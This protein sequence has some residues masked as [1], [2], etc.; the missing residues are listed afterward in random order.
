MVILDDDH[1][2]HYGILRKSGRYP[3]G[4][5]GNT[6]LERSQDF[7]SIT[8]TL[9]EQGMNEG[10]IAKAVGL[11]RSQLR[12]TKTI[13][14]N[15]QRQARIIEAQRLSDKGYG[16]TAAAAKMGI[17][18]STYRSL[19][20]PGA[21]DRSDILTATTDTL[22]KEVAE[23]KYVDVGTGVETNLGISKEKLR[24]AASILEEEGYPIHQVNFPQAATGKETRMKVLCAKG[25]TQKE[26]WLNRSEIRPPHSFSDDGGRTYGGLKIHD[27]IA[28]DPKRVSIKYGDEGGG[29]ADGVIFVRPGVKDLSLGKANYAQVRVKVGNDHYLKGMA[30]YKDDLPA[31]TDLL[32]NTAKKS[33]GNKFDAMKPI[34]DDPD[35]PFGSVVRQIL[36]DKG[37]DTEHVTSAMNLVY[38]EGNWGSW[39]KSLSSQFLSKQDPKVARDQLDLTFKRRKQEL[40]DLLVLTNPTVKKKLLE[41]YAGKAD[42]SAVHLE[43]AQMNTRQQW[44]AILPIE[45]MPHSHVYAPN[46]K[47]GEPVVL[48]RYPHAGRFEI[49]ELTVDNNNREARKLIGNAPD[50]I[51]IHTSVAHRLSGADFDGDTVIVIPNQGR[52]IK[53]SPALAGLKNFDPQSAYPGY[54]GMELLSPRRKQQEMGK[55]SNL[56]TDMTIK[57]AD[58]EEI[59][60][61]VR[62]SMA[63]ID[64]EKH[65]IDWKTSSQLNGIPALKTKYQGGATKGASTLLSRAGGP[66]YI[67]ERK[68]RPYKQGG[69]VNPKTGRLEFVET[70]RT[71]LDRSGQRVLR[72]QKVKRL[73]LEEDAY[74]L[75][76]G[77]PMEALYADHANRFKSLANQARLASINTPR[78]NYSPSAHKAYAK[79]VKELNANLTL[80]KK[81]AVLERQAQLLARVTYRAKLQ[82]NPHL[83]DAAKKKVKFQ[84]LTNARSRVGK[85]ELDFKITQEQW[86]AIQAGAI[87]NN[88]LKQILD[89]CDLESVQKLATPHVERLMTTSKTALAKSLLS[90][91][92][93]RAE[94]AAR[95]GV[96]TATLDRSVNEGT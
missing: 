85:K 35:Y 16:N 43:A 47:N 20:A 50:A 90:S 51:G 49:P 40:D 83:S 26:A 67:P 96:S 30:M 44:H 69:P 19:L 25:V 65:P 61:A 63:I 31:G 60:R 41:A 5:G 94:V 2:E 71:R 55:I 39:T 56:I 53:S 62:H 92:Y 1:I 18:E 86:N 28:I 15:Q 88:V 12:D 22:R 34:T 80:T 91:G 48:I 77:T 89:H 70:G 24:T 14:L 27:P 36:A 84:E 7:F 4:S 58:H 6:A 95:L 37:K 54:E 21:K 66:K 10:E 74:A 8:N 79:E 82:A 78:L 29:A 75:S 33:T 73:A 3:W 72:K 57:G 45:S 64:A 13:A 32:F 42:S 46:Y 38:E 59:A 87:S 76:S 93:T 11:T 9:K 81:N 23:K 52:K 17:P 68:P